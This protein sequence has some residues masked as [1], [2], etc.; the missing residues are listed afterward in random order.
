MQPTP[1]G[2]EQA[3]IIGE[4]FIGGDDCAF[5]LGDNI[6]YGHELPKLMDTAVDKES[7]ATVF[8]YHVIDPERY[9][10]VEFDKTVWQKSLEEKPLQPKSNQ[11]VKNWAFIS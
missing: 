5:V 10:V 8:A 2:L 7:G 11:A 4:E 3:F 9:G 1:D 6:F